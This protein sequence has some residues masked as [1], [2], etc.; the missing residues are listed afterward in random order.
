MAKKTVVDEVR[1]RIE[2][3]TAKK[4]HDMEI[5]YAEL[6]KVQKRKSAAAA[7]AEAAYENMDLDAFRLAEAEAAEAEMAERMYSSRLSQIRTQEIVTEEDSDQVI[8]SLRGYL[9]DKESEFEIALIRPLREIQQLYDQYIEA[10][11]DGE[12]AIL[13]W[14]TNVH[15]NY[16]AD[17]STRYDPETGTHTNRML[18]PVAVPTSDGKGCGTARMVNHFLLNMDRLLVDPEEAAGE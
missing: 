14:T 2:A 8:G 17:Y 16:R 10:V 6:S 9:R 18:R 12:G 3:I 13:A 7:A 4:A 15:K 11:R 5:V 1:E